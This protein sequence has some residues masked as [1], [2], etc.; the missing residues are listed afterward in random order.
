MM[1]VMGEGARKLGEKCL[2]EV[3]EG[4]LGDVLKSVRELRIEREDGAQ[5]QQPR[6]TI[7]S[8][9]PALDGLLSTSTTHLELISPPPSH[10]PSGAGKTAL[11]HL[12]IAHAILPSALASI[13]LLGQNATI[14]LFD[15]LHHFSIPRLASVM[16]NILLTRT[17][18][19]DKPINTSDLKSLIS[20]CLLHVHIFRP[21]S[22][23]ALL[24]TLRT[25]PDYLLDA[26]RHR[27]MHRRIHAIVLEDVDAFV[28]SL[29]DQHSAGIKATTNTLSTAS[30]QLTS[31]LRR[32][33]A[34]FACAAIVSAHSASPASLRP[35]LP[36]QWPQ[37]MGVT[38]LA[39][40]RVGVN[41][42]KPQVSVEEAE[43]ERGKRWEVVSRGR[44][45]CW[46]VGVGVKD[47]EGFV[48]R[49]GERGV[50]IE[51]DEG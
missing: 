6:P 22:W 39:L 11:L 4:S 18:A 46:K 29:R 41:K 20:T 33:T 35:A 44:F 34:Q 30:A 15:P 28:A 1:S 42:F 19:S 40:R 32:F 10:H 5:T 23:P 45:E 8:G 50:E 38:R 12:I 27:S 16:L 17:N 37:D 2:G 47:G 7:F 3:E 25:L 26:S 51:R 24:A 31:L 21:Q 9:I 49:V 13:P 14:I 43:G 36:L 48:F